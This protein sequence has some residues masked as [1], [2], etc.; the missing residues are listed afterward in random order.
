M[1][2]RRPCALHVVPPPPAAR[3]ADLADAVTEDAMQL[4]FAVHQ[5]L[6]EIAATVPDAQPVRATQRNVV[7]TL[8]VLRCVGDALRLDAA[9]APAPPRAA[10][11][12]PERLARPRIVAP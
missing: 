1:E 10:T 5:D 9:L 4:L 12:G 7:R 8:E 6:A 11:R 3:R 2:P